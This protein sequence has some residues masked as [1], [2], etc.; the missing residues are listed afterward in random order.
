[1]TQTT[2]T[3]PAPTIPDDVQFESA[4]GKA[5]EQRIGPGLYIGQ[6]TRIE[7]GPDGQY[8]ANVYSYWAL[9]NTVEKDGKQEVVPAQFNEDGTV[10]EWRQKT[11]VKFGKNPKSGKTAALRQNAEALLKREI[12]D[13]EDTRA[14]LQECLGKAAM[15]HIKSEQGSDGNMYLGLG[16][17]EPYRKGMVAPVQRFEPDTDGETTTTD[18]SDVPF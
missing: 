13:D 5:F 16:M 11:T 9:H 3:G 18:D 6:L 1:M 10:Y 17:I 15:L 8:G 7:K 2:H 4:K 14:V 12:D